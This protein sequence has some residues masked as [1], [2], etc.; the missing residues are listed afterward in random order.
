M[1]WYWPRSKAEFERYRERR[2]AAVAAKAMR[3]RLGVLAGML[4]VLAALGYALFK[5]I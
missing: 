5:L 3:G 2:L 4:I 1:S